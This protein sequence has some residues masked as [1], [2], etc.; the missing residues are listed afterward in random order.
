MLRNHRLGF[1]ALALAALVGFAVPAAAQSAEVAPTK[2]D[3]LRFEAFAVQMQGGM[4][5]MVMITIERWT[6]EEERN[7]LVGLL[8]NT[9]I[10]EQD[11]EKLVKALQDIK[12]RAGY[13]NTPN[14]MG[15]DIKY[16]YQTQLA[17]GSRQVVVVT[18]KPVSFFAASRNTRTMD[19]AFTLIEMR[20]P[21]GS[22]KGEGK[23]LGQTS[24]SVKDGKLQIEIYGQ[25]P[26]RLTQI[27]E[28]TP[29]VKK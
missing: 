22:D 10:R 4:A 20:F 24:L 12:E 21:K 9:T 5:G 8:A 7:A 19:Y 16:A 26:T 13:L 25:E 23:L 29:K 1:G 27:T 28:K 15:W 18:D 3:P 14:S 17:D 11:Q 6:T 2:K